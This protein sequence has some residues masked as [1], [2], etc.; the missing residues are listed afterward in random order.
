M[1]HTLYGRIALARRAWYERPG[2]QRSL[3]RPVVSVGNLS[4]GGT[5][6]TPLV[7][8]LA[9]HLVASGERPA[10]L[11]RGYAR[12]VATRDP[13]VVSDGT[14]VLA[15]VAQAGDEPMML[16]RA[17]R[18]ARVVVSDDRHAAGV[19][20]EASLGATVHV[21]DDG[22]QHV[23]LARDLDIVVTPAGALG[24]DA[25][26]PKGRLREPVTALSRASLL[27]VV[28]ASD[29]EADAEARAVGVPVGL[30]ARRRLGAP[31][32]RSGAPP[33]RQAPLVVM[34]GIGQPAQF[35]DGLRADGWIVADVCLFRDHHWY[36]ADDLARVAG[37][38]AATGA[39][40]V[41]T[42]DKDLV[43][44][45]P[46]VHPSLK[47]AAWP[48]TLELPRWDVLAGAVGAVLA[49]RA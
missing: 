40:G 20:A 9:S 32:A 3:G 47:M 26:L 17:V 11:S 5:G 42:T 18:G 22:F 16:A 19:L 2:G 21:L 33:D 34:A 13:V 4:V 12:R 14:D 41:A 46:E 27:V 31:V 24:T 35:V 37:R 48:L 43:R 28:G 23:R 15:D 36:T 39:W 25:V 44:L 1:L 49:R 45:G 7:A 29:A 10:I 30:A 38:V 6:K 8:A